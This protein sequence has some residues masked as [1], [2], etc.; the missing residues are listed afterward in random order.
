MII[1]R[2][3]GELPDIS[4]LTLLQEALKEE[5]WGKGATSAEKDQI[6]VFFPADKLGKGEKIA[7][8]VEGDL[9]APKTL[10]SRQ[11]LAKRI[12]SLLEQF[13]QVYVPCCGGVVV[14][15]REVDPKEEVLLTTIFPQ[16]GKA[17]KE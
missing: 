11:G 7:V 5:I 12:R 3:Y 8:F 17:G 13:A 9:P 2:I 4:E 1:V 10:F 14:D 16:V 6:L 15:V